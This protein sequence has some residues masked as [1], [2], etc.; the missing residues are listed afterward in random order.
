MLMITLYAEQKKS[1]DFFN[2]PAKK[3]DVTVFT[4]YG[5]LLCGYLFG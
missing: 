2:V 1:L 5:Y 4:L 3:S